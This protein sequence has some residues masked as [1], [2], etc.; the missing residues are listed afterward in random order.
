MDTIKRVILGALI[1]AAICMVLGINSPAVNIEVSTTGGND[2]TSLARPY[3]RDG[4][5]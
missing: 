1:T 2:A 4:Q 5:P 3:A